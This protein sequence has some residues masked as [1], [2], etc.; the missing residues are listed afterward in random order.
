MEDMG[1]YFRKW[2]NQD[3]GNKS[4]TSIKGVEGELDIGPMTK[5]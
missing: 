2:R 4:S 3:L 5:Q 1:S